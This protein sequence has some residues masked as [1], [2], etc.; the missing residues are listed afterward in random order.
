MTWLA[1]RLAGRLGDGVRIAQLRYAT[2]S[3][4]RY[5]GTVADVAAALEAEGRL[6]G[7]RHDGAPR[8]I[9][10]VGLSMG[11]GTCLANAQAEGVLGLVAISPWFPP[12]VPMANLEGRV[13]RVVHGLWDRI[14]PFVPGVPPDASREFVARAA[15]AGVDARW[16]GIPY[17]PH[18]LAVRRG[19]R[20]VA[21][22]RARAFA[23]AV[24]DDVEELLAPSRDPGAQPAQ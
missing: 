6:V 3:W 19:S 23:R 10:L 14:L 22:P 1:P 12:Q 24:L 16:R 20:V 4:Q 5:A 17:G 13:L 7:G 21:L 11:G 9:V 8:R 2:S 18:G 15:A